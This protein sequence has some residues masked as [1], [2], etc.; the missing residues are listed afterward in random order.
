MLITRI[1][2]IFVVLFAITRTALPQ[3][4]SLVWADEFDKPGLPDPSKWSY[5]TA[6]NASGWGN[7][8]W[9][10]YTAAD[11]DNAMVR[12]G[13]LHIRAIR[14]KAGGK[15]FTS[16]RLITKGKGDWLYGRVEVRAKLPGARGIWPAIWMLPTDWEYGG[17]PESGEID[18]MEHV[19][20]MPDSVFA[21]VHTKS[22]NHLIGTHPVKGRFL[23]NIHDGFH[24]YSLE[25]N[26]QE[27]RMYADDIHYFTFKKEPSGPDAWP[28]DKRFHLLLNVAV[29]GN[30]GA[31]K[32]VN[33]KAF[34]QEMVV[35]Y[36]RVRQ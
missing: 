15:N 27:I 7:N 30:W 25:W 16:A 33:E 4:N 12:D 29:G 5:D 2:S 1:S 21:A 22:Y 20:F 35:D 11:P 6:G 14:E 32:G 13:C 26:T 36:V 3:F 8:E 17:W 19:G 23:E 10:F 28:F 31:M 9:Q 18:I 34:P 24:V